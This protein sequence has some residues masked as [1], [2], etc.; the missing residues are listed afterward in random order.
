MTTMSDKT[1]AAKFSPERT[2]VKTNSFSNHWT[3]SSELRV[4]RRPP[5]HTVSIPTFF[6]NYIRVNTTVKQIPNFMYLLFLISINQ[7]V[8]SHLSLFPAYSKMR[9]PTCQYERTEGGTRPACETPLPSLPTGA[10]HSCP[11]GASHVHLAEAQTAACAGKV[12]RKTT[13]QS[14]FLTLQK[15][16]T[17]N[18]KL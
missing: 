1:A 18:L 15:A 12:K 13:F 14:Q 17:I 10:G 2:A 7:S 5:P 4:K 11:P 9:L 16:V 3:L 8:S 6:S